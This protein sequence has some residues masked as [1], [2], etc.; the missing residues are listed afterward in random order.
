MVWKIP[1]K[2]G[3]S[4]AKGGPSGEVQIESDGGWREHQHDVITQWF[5]T[6]VHI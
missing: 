2:F 4:Y 6:V 3:G 5:T 1:Q